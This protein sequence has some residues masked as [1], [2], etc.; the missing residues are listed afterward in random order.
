M[1]FLRLGEA[2][3]TYH[4]LKYP[5]PFERP[6]TAS[7]PD[8]VYAEITSQTAQIRALASEHP[9]LEPLRQA[10][11]VRLQVLLKVEIIQVIAVV[12]RFDF[13]SLRLEQSVDGYAHI[14][15]P[16]FN[17]DAMIGVMRARQVIA[18]LLERR[19][20]VITEGNVHLCDGLQ[21]WFSFGHPLCRPRLSDAAVQTYMS[22]KAAKRNIE[23]KVAPAVSAT[24]PISSPQDIYNQL[25]QYVLAND[26]A[27]RSLAVRGSMHLSRRE[28][29]QQG[30]EVGA[31]EC[32]L[33]IG[34]S[35]T[36]KTYLA[37]TF[38][39]LCGLPFAS[40]SASSYTAS[41][42][43]GLDADDAILALVRSVGDPKD[44]QA[45]E[46]ARYGV[47]FMDEWDKR[48]INSGVGVDVGGSSV[49]Y[50]FL[51][52]ISGTKMIL[53][54]RRPDRAEHPIEFNSNGTLFVFAGA[55]TGLEGIIK[56]L[57]K[58]R[59]QMGFSGTIIPKRMPKVYD[60]LQEFG[61]VPEFLNRVSAIIA[62][63]P[64]DKADLVHIATSQHG[65]IEAYN[66][67]LAKQGIRM[68]LTPQALD[69]MA[70]FCVDTKLFCRGIQLIVS[71]LVEEAIFNCIKTN[72]LFDKA[73][74]QQAL[75]RIVSVD[76]VG[77]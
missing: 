46:R 31:N 25:K 4:A 43:V 62:M 1:I 61:V 11:G 72:T 76:G 65:A 44:Q 21:D 9:T 33:L 60:A 37:E 7:D 19:A 58:E 22:N 39:K 26:S 70:E 6:T 38:G 18:A 63:K 23:K 75:D 40:L 68:A 64:L 17:H 3:T 45:I 54:A 30:A 52:L 8:K 77:Q 47:L 69:T 71:S 29:L 27:C 13:A 48:K 20:L 42:Y 50:E 41:G 28:L 51:R 55:F 74:V 59:A 2:I 66:R 24:T 73:E 5:D 35:G 34:Q 36:G 56:H 10:L 57:S 49:Q 15:S 67:I 16:L 12:A 53:G 32:I 14:L